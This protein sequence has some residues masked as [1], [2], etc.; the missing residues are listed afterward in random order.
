MDLFE[1]F[2]KEISKASFLGQQLEKERPSYLY[3]VEYYDQHDDYFFILSDY[4]E[5]KINKII[6]D[7]ID[8]FISENGVFNKEVFDRRIL[9]NFREEIYAYLDS[10]KKGKAISIENFKDN[11]N[12]IRFRLPYNETSGKTIIITTKNEIQLE[13]YL[14]S[15]IEISQNFLEEFDR[16]YIKPSEEQ[17]NLKS[18]KKVIKQELKSFKIVK[19]EF[20]KL[21][22]FRNALIDDGFIDKKISLT[23]FRKVFDNK[24]VEEKII[25]KKAYTQLNYLIKTLF[26][27]SI[28][29][30]DDDKKWIITA[31]CFVVQKK[32]GLINF[33]PEKIR[34]SNKTNPKSDSEIRRILKS[35]KIL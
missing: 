33:N 7:K 14:K 20:D 21:S 17:T 1:I 22:N 5:P 13:I 16:H 18:D 19:G 27:E 24:I 2:F 26:E 23:N 11:L 29:T 6:K 25:W 28:I 10:F 12:T 35:S 30:Q 4:D 9:K 3:D 31:N 34:T 32:D 15:V 8:D